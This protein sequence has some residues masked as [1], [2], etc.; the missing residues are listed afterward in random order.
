[1]TTYRNLGRLDDLGIT[2]ITL[3]RRSPRLLGEISALPPSAWRR[4]SLDVPAPK[5]KTP[6]VY[7][8]SVRLEGH[9]FRQLFVLD[10]GHDEP[11]I[12]LTLVS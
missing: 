12:L 6:R 5:Y 11:T 8:G 10:L 2:F 3:R 9:T 7:T 4:V 1:L